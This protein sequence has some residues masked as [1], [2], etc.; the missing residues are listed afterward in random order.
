MVKNIR[1]YLL[2]LILGAI[3][4]LG[5]FYAFV[6]EALGKW[7]QRVDNARFYNKHLWS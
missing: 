7:L 3:L 2:C 1:D 4:S 5:V 6:P